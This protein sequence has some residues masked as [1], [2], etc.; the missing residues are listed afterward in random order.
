M[1]GGSIGYADETDPAAVYVLDNPDKSAG[2][3]YT[4]TP[5]GL[6]AAPMEG[7]PMPDKA[8]MPP[9]AGPMK[10]GK[11]G[12]VEVLSYVTSDTSFRQC[13]GG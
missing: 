3:I 13:T 1:V 2:R 6:V 9:V 7:A 12:G 10:P 11:P 8:P 4:V 5:E